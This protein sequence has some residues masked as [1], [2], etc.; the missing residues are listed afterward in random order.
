[1]TLANAITWAIDYI[2]TRESDNPEARA[3][4]RELDRKAERERAKREK[5]A[6]WLIRCFCGERRERRQHVCP[7]C[8]PLIPMKTWIAFHTGRGL[9]RKRA[10][11]QIQT[12][13]ECRGESTRREAA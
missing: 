1:M 13:C 2:R 4:L 11:K 8:Y 3:V 7:D 10:V 5:P 9:E 6:T 12:L